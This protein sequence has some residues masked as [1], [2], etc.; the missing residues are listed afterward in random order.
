MRRSRH[1]TS[2]VELLVALGILGL[3]SG[4]LYQIVLRTHDTQQDLDM[5]QRLIADS[6]LIA[7][8]ISSNLANLVP[9]P[10]RAGEAVIYFQGHRN[11]II[12]SGIKQGG[13]YYT[14]HQDLSR[15]ASRKWSTVEFGYH[16]RGTDVSQWEPTWLNQTELPDMIKVS[17]ISRPPS[18][19]RRGIVGAVLPVKL[20]TI[21]PVRNNT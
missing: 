10:V 15:Y 6:R 12:F 19:K 21:I 8:G 18:N 3:L 4:L 16:R 1:G 7:M 14:S 2:L 11:K 13:I 9:E 17:I 5:Q 20:E